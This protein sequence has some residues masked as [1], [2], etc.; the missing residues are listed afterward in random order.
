[1]SEVTTIKTKSKSTKKIITKHEPQ[2]STHYHHFLQRNEFSPT[3]KHNIPTR[4][5]KNK[6]DKNN[7][8]N[9]KSYRTLNI[10]KDDKIHKNKIRSMRNTKNNFYKK[11]INKS[12]S[13]KSIK[14]I[15]LKKN[16]NTNKKSGLKI[17]SPDFD[18]TSLKIKNKLY[19]SN[20]YFENNNNLTLNSKNNKISNNYRNI[21][22]EHN[23]KELTL[24]LS[25]EKNNTL[26][27]GI[28][29]FE[30]NAP[31]K[32]ES[33]I[34]QKSEIE[35]KSE[36]GI[37]DVRKNLFD[38]SK[39]KTVETN[40]TVSVYIHK[41]MNN[42]IITKPKLIKN[43]TKLKKLKINKLIN[44]KNRISFSPKINRDLL[45]IKQNIILNHSLQKRIINNLSLKNQSKDGK[46][47]ETKNLTIKINNK[48]EKKPINFKYILKKNIN[49]NKANSKIRKEVKIAEKPKE[50]ITPKKVL[51]SHKNSSRNK[52]INHK[53]NDLKLNN[54]KKLDD[55]S[56]NKGN[57]KRHLNNAKSQTDIEADYLIKKLEKDSNDISK[58]QETSTNEIK[59][60]E[61]EEK[62]IVRLDSICKKGFA[63]PG[64]K[65]ICQD[66]YFIFNNLV[67]NKDYRFMGICDGHG[68]NGQEVSGYLSL[69]LPQNLNEKLLSE[70]ITNLSDI[71]IS[72]ISETV[73]S[74]FIETNMDLISDESIDTLFSGSTC[75]SIICTPK[76][77]IS[78]NVG[79]S[80]CVV[81]KFDGKNWKAKNLSRDHKPSEEDEFERIIKSGG[82]VESYK[83]E[84]GDP[85]GPERVWLKDEDFPGLAMSR[86]FGDEV[87]HSA[88][89]IVEPEIS[90]YYFVHEDKFVIIASDGIFE[91][92]SSDE[93][94]SMLKN[95]YL[96]DDIDGAMYY[97]YK[98]SSKKWI[99]EEEVIDDI[100]MILIF[101]N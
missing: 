61:I 91:F 31:K 51:K 84:D 14:E 79:D 11:N 44:N 18:N 77:I 50:L 94:V 29:L 20:K 40:K 32:S 90:E 8:L 35:N 57:Q 59:P 15:K 12:T 80:R 17:K 38:D 70:K 89:V 36:N 62:K 25:V 81:G 27:N 55:S 13:T 22:D 96:K 88:G 72:K 1:M 33:I 74:I 28:T 26:L 46:I 45:N 56:N 3:I 99:M 7:E 73:S 60:N 41:K 4:F 23:K 98:E 37:I 75:C 49:N 76:K 65:K 66:N 39:N 52:N 42:N 82:R 85:V 78:I 101:L 24:C 87:A 54:D 97:L 6:I 83:N 30:P 10:L 9:S 63:G 86:S 92:I 64:V 48:K 47:N 68:A 16:T 2:S 58:N 53:I 69:Y 93:C 19:S 67:D 34:V 100:S 5:N 21:I 95:F 43:K 71:N